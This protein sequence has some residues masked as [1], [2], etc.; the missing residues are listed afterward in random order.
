MRGQKLASYLLAMLAKVLET[1]YY[2]DLLCSDAGLHLAFEAL[3][4]TRT[5]SLPP[6]PSRPRPKT[7]Q[8]GPASP[9]LRISS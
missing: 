3:L 7:R 5:P 1:G 8:L 6:G 4:A 9:K 2:L